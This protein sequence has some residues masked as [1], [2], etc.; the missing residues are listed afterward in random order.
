MKSIVL[1]FIGVFY[2]FNLIA[3]TNTELVKDNK[4]SRISTPKL[5]VNDD[6][7]TIV[8]EMGF[9]GSIPKNK[10]ERIKVDQI[11]SISLVYTK[12]KLSDD[13]NQLE[14]NAQR[15]DKLY[16]SIPALKDNKSIKWYWIEQTG[17]S[18]PEDCNQLFHGFVISLKPESS[19]VKFETTMLDDYLTIY[20]AKYLND[21]KMD[22]LIAEKKLT[23]IKT[24]DTIHEVKNI[25]SNR[26]SRISG[27]NDENKRKLAKTLTKKNKNIK[28]LKMDLIINLA[29]ELVAETPES[30][31]KEETKA[32]KILNKELR[33]IPARYLGKKIETKVNLQLTMMENNVKLDVIQTPILPN[34]QAFDLDKF[35]YQRTT[36]IK[37]EY[38]DT[39]SKK[40]HNLYSNL[41]DDVVLRAFE[42]NKQWKN[43]LIATDVT[44][45]MYPYL[46]Q[47]KLWHKLHLNA[48][49]GNFDFVFFNDG[50]NSAD[51]LKKTGE[52][53]G[54][55]Y[56][57]TKDFDSLSQTLNTAMTSGGG[58]DAPENNIEAVIKGLKN[59][60]KVK[61][62]IMIA[63][64]NAT[65][66]DLILLSKVKVPLRLILCG[67][68]NGINLAYLEMIRK[69]KGSIHTMENDLLDLC[70]KIEGEKFKLDGISYQIK[71]GNIIKL[72]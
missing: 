46:A 64:N 65:P 3:Q 28:D 68:S 70:L 29:G 26:L 5:T 67:A 62:V 18:S 49:Q 38:K 40:T 48:K 57:N 22:S 17:C 19:T 37:C 43:C 66:R 72:N 35:L 25:T 6:D 69:N 24:C 42:R 32:L 59:N 12:Y 8:L 51:F 23:Y 4:V 56:V 45:S 36:S 47:F 31:S 58:G 14:L 7:Y 52:V 60:P 20:E 10:L 27:F 41:S 21:E 54:I 16:A 39:S 1:M 53:G 11:A 61:E 50:D 9:N 30:L 2:A 33:I 15:L 63:D 13:F 71:N 34:N 55:Y 44:G